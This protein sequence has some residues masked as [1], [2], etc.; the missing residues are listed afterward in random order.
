MRANVVIVL[1]LGLLRAGAATVSIG[2]EVSE[3]YSIG[4]GIE[5]Y[6]GWITTHDMGGVIT[7]ETSFDGAQA[8]KIEANESPVEVRYQANALPQ[9]GIRCIELEIKPAVAG[10]EEEGS[11]LHLLVQTSASHGDLGR[12]ISDA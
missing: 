4:C 11:A 6:S 2:F 12:H 10:S 8:L 9:G 3:G 5:A 7:G 1:M